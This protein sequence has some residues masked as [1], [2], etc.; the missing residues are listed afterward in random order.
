MEIF[1]LGFDISQLKNIE[2]LFAYCKL[3]LTNRRCFNVEK[4]NIQRK[5]DLARYREK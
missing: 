1:Q 3:E 4:K 5:D 2:P